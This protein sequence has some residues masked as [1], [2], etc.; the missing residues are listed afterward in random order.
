MEMMLPI[1]NSVYAKFATADNSNIPACLDRHLVT[2]E[3]QFLPKSLAQD[4][5]FWSPSPQ[6]YVTGSQSS[7]VYVHSRAD[8]EPWLFSQIPTLS[9][10]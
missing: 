6:V 3:L 7:L 1:A 5:K 8:F 2:I 10:A 4:W 9:C